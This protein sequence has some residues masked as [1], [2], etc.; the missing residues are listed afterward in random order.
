MRSKT[1]LGMTCLA[2][3]ALSAPSIHPQADAEQGSQ[4]VE[5]SQI[6]STIDANAAAVAARDMDA[7]LATYEPEAVLAG[8]PGKPAMGTAALRESFNYFLALEPKITIANQ[9]VYQAGD[10]ALHSYTWKMAGKAPDGTTVEQSGL[11]VI[12]LRKQ[13]DGRWL[14]VIDNPFGDRF[15]QK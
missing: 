4:A 5:H 1:L 12:V 13:A 6:Q 8:Q 11:S 7:I 14:M 2:I 10:I 3:L 15:L 9:E